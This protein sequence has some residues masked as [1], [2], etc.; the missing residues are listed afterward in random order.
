MIYLARNVSHPG[1]VPE[2]T[3]LD[4]TGR[5]QFDSLD[6]RTQ[7]H[8]LTRDREF[9]GVERLRPQIVTLTIPYA[10]HDVPAG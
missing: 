10:M 7:G 6:A 4:L 1:G 5:S 9:L 3:R 8:G 2:Q